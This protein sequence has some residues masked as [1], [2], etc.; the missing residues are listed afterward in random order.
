MDR[1]KAGMTLKWTDKQKVGNKDKE[2][3]DDQIEGKK[4]KQMI[5]GGKEG[6]E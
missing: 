4:N 5:E 2:R 6:D 3:M 1:K